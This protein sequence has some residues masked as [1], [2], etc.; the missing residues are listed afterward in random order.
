MYSAKKTRS[1]SFTLGLVCAVLFLLICTST[2]V[3]AQTVVGRIS[4]TIRDATGA[5]VP[6][7]TVTRLTQP[8]I[9]REQP[10]LT[11][12]DFIL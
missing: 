2:G 4:G 8:L 12:V 1:S 10:R 6:S 5:V 9:R 11:T 7:A 3:I